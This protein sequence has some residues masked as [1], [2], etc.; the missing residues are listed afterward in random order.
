M[1]TSNIISKRI[2]ITPC[3]CMSWSSFSVCRRSTHWKNPFQVV[4]NASSFLHTNIHWNLW[5]LA[6][7]SAFLC[8]CL[9]FHTGNRWIDP[10]LQF[11]LRSISRFMELVGQSIYTVPTYKLWRTKLYTEFE[12]A[13]DNVYRYNVYHLLVLQ[14]GL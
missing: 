10:E 13:A 2:N 9:V 8:R 4:R 12:T 3:H 7:R 11:F 5:S 1:N 14:K 6:S